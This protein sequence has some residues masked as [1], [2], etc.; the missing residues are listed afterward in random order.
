MQ[1]APARP[2]KTMPTTD[3]QTRLVIALKAFTGTL[4]P[5]YASE[6]EYFLVA[7]QDMEEYLANLQKEALEESRGAFLRLLDAGKVTPESVGKL[8]AALARLVREAAFVPVKAG[9]AG[10]KD[11]VKQRL[12]RL[13]PVSLLAEGK[14]G[15]GR[16]AAAEK[17]IESAYRRLGFPALARM[18][19]ADPSGPSANSALAKARGNVAGYC[20]A[21]CVPAGDEVPFTPAGLACVDA[22][23]AAC[24]RL[25]QNIRKAMGRSF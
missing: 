4:P 14:K 21:N 6:T 8:E 12:A 17:E 2:K 16:D 11:L 23:L 9:M 18:V 20:A 24:F 19:G 22:A 15:A 1:D 13:V 10:S 7:L 5:M 3:N 25:F